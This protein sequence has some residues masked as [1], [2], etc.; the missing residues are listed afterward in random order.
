MNF[1]V[2]NVDLNKVIILFQYLNWKNGAYNIPQWEI[3][4]LVISDQ[5][6]PVSENWSLLAITSLCN[7]GTSI[8]MTAFHGH[9]NVY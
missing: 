4:A 5:N 1:R 8:E 6:T 9:Y 2:N 7:F 3:A